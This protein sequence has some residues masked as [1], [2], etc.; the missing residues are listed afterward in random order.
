MVSIAPCFDQE[1]T[2]Q[3]RVIPLSRR[4]SVVSQIGFT[5]RGIPPAMRQLRAQA[6]SVVSLGPQAPAASRW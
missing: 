5:T 4:L 2:R 1:T 6:R 3:E